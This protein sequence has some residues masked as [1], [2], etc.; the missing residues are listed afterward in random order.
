MQDEIISLDKI[1]ST[2]VVSAHACML[3]PPIIYL[4]LNLMVNLN[5]YLILNLTLNLTSV[6]VGQASTS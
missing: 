1:K 2:I 5:L 6:S 3:L 4:T